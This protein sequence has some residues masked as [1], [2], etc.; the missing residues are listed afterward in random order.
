[1]NTIKKWIHYIEILKDYN[2]KLDLFIGFLL[3]PVMQVNIKSL[4]I[5]DLFQGVFFFFY[6]AFQKHA[7]DVKMKA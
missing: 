4:L 1:M 6:Q 7:V 5:C 2:V 3:L